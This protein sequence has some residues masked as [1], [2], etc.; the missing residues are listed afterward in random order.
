MVTDLDVSVF[1]G[2]ERDGRET[3]DDATLQDKYGCSHEPIQGHD[4]GRAIDAGFATLRARKTLEGIFNGVLTF[5][6]LQKVRYRMS[7][8]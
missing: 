1:P 7:E 6:A 4:T 5:F 2:E 3:S 8:S